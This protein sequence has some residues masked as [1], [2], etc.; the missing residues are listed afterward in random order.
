MFE[1]LLNLLYPDSCLACHKGNLALCESCIADIPDAPFI[2]DHIYSRFAYSHKTMRTAI[3]NLKYRHASR[4]APILGKHLAD[5]IIEDLSEDIYKTEILPVLVAAPLSRERLRERG[6]NQA[7]LLAKEVSKQIGLELVPCIEKI[8]H[9]E[10]QVNLANKKSRLTNL[11]G[12][13]S[14]TPKASEKIE[15]KNL[16]LIDDVYTTGATIKEIQKE[17]RKAQ[18]KS[19]KAYT[20]AH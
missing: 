8:R 4:L 2:D 9:T 11:V 13:F 18:P 6:F 19:I 14:L 10:S 5:L 1:Y 12:A 17:L 15:S 3:R 20:L 16:I 7:E